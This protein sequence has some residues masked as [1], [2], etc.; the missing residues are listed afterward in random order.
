LITDAFRRA[1]GKDVADDHK[2]NS[3]TEKI[4]K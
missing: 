4:K 2:H 1:F 3:T